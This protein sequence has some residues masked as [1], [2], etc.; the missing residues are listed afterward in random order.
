[1]AD[2]LRPRLGRCA[3]GRLGVAGGP[4]KRSQFARRQL[5][6]FAHREPLQLQGSHLDSTKLSHRMADSIHHST[7]LTV[8]AL[9]K[10]D[11][12]TGP[13]SISA[14]HDEVAFGG[15]DRLTGTTIDEVETA[16]NLVE[17]LVFD[18]PLHGDVVPLVNPVS[19]VGQS[20]G[21]IAV[22]GEQQQPRALEVETPHAEEPALRRMIDEIEG[23]LP[24]LGILGRADVAL[25]LE[26]HDV[27]VSTPLLDSATVY[28]D[29]VGFGVHEAWKALNDGA[30]HGDRTV[31]D[32]CFGG[33]TRCDAR[34]G[35][36]LLDP[37]SIALPTM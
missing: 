20:V 28:S 12:Q 32:E 2:L 31:L 5:S 4:S 6:P 8:P 25:G 24:S 22:V 26:Q 18:P 19:R 3:S 13:L 35:Q 27:V 11:E 34:V 36:D 37:D 33:S 9:P 14:E 16:T 21:E 10:G 29:V 1:M 23:E 7:D 17:D 30:V 15:P